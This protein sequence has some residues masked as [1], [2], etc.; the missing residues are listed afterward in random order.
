MTVDGFNLFFQRLFSG[1]LLSLDTPAL[2][3]CCLSVA[4]RFLLGF[5]IQSV[6]GGL[7]SRRASQLI[8]ESLNFSLSR[9]HPLLSAASDTA[10]RLF[11]RCLAKRYHLSR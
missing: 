2:F 7:S 1:A 4:M 3:F 8:D 9:L 6:G 5:P 11:N 10:S